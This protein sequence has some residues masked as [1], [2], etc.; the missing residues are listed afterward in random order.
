MLDFAKRSATVLIITG[1][2]AV[3][4]GIFALS[5]PFPTALALVLVWG[6]YALIDGVLEIIAAFRPE[7]RSSR[8]F[9]L[10][11]GIIGVIAGL[12]VIFRTLDSAIAIAWILGI[13]LILRGVSELLSAAVPKEGAS[14]LFLGLSG[15]LFIIAG[16]IFIA[17]PGSAALAVSTVLGVLAI[18]WGAFTLFGGVSILRERNRIKSAVDSTTTVD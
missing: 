12:L 1:V 7:H 2:V 16:V 6:W 18:A 15:V 4:F 5:S 11:T 3:I 9:L 13:W 14:R 10:T 8:G 17:N